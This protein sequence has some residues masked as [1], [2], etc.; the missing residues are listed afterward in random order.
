MGED[1]TN[2]RERLARKRKQMK[3]GHHYNSYPA[4]H[5]VCDH[6]N[7]LRL[8]R[9]TV[10]DHGWRKATVISKLPQNQYTI[11]FDDSGCTQ[12]VSAGDYLIERNHTNLRLEDR[13]VDAY[14]RLAAFYA[15]RQPRS[16][17]YYRCYGVGIRRGMVL[18]LSN[19][20][21]EAF[22]AEILGSE[23]A[24]IEAKISEGKLPNHVIDLL[25]DLEQAIGDEFS[26]ENNKE[27]DEGEYRA[28][29]GNPVLAHMEQKMDNRVLTLTCS[30]KCWEEAKKDPVRMNKIRKD[31]RLKKQ[32]ADETEIRARTKA[33]LQKE[34]AE[35]KKR[36][37]K[38]RDR[39]IKVLLRYVKA[40]DTNSF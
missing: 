25:A 3:Q 31:E 21:T 14:N 5:Y 11:R 20:T 36:E 9:L 22:V 32:K 38:A 24:S 12:T 27:K 40:G 18:E 29:R 26:K 8:F 39:V 1:Q 4:T 15:C 13:V 7:F 35:R 17:Y 28:K 23:R 10:R 16:G 2:L 33:R 34:E 6:D 19:R 30:E 37:L